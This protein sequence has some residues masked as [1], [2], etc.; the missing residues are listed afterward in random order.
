MELDHQIVCV[1]SASYGK[2]IGRPIVHGS[3]WVR[4]QGSNK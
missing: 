2:G 4:S 1:D 3:E